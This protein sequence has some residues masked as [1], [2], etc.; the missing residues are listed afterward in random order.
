MLYNFKI[1]SVLNMI[2][3]YSHIVR[4]SSVLRWLTSINST[5]NEL[6]KVLLLEIGQ[7][8]HSSFT[9]PNNVVLHTVNTLNTPR[10]TAVFPNPSPRAHPAAHIFILTLDKHT[11]FNLS[12]N[13][14]A[15]SE[16]NEVCLSRGTQGWKH[17]STELVV[18]LKIIHWCMTSN[19]IFLWELYTFSVSLKKFKNV[20]SLII[21]LWKYLKSTGSVK[22]GY[23]K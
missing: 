17:C 18:L 15:H 22:C 23:F 2:T 20:F 1:S 9:N 3:K 5:A 8:I 21:T 6:L 16:L 12:T 10:S 4:R 11:W 19:V 13:H 7:W 14:Q